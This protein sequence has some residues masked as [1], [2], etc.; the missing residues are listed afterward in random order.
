MPP[1]AKPTESN[2]N[3]NH[4]TNNINLNV[5]IPHTEQATNKEKSEPNWWTRTVIGGIIALILSLCG[6]YLKNN[7]DK[8]K[9]HST[10]GDP[11]VNPIEAN[12]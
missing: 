8:D 5:N 12:H 1:K 11:V 9:V 10:T 6:Y 4:N 2:V 3:N 7:M